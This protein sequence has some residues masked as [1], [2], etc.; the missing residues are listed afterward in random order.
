MIVKAKN[1]YFTVMFVGKYELLAV[2]MFKACESKRVL[3]QCAL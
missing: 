1:V 3:A 2:L